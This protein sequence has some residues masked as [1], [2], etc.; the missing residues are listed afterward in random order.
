MTASASHA[1]TAPRTSPASLSEWFPATLTTLRLGP[2]GGIPN[3]SL[4]PCTTSVGT[5]TASSSPSR[6]F[7]GSSPFPGGCT[8]KEAEQRDR[9]EVRGGAARHSRTGRASAHDERKALEA[10]A[11]KL[12]DDR[13]P[14]GIQLPRRGGR[15]SPGDHVGL[16]D[17]GDGDLGVTRRLGGRDEIGGA[18]SARGAVP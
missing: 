5:A 18:H 9:T 2:S 8:G 1:D 14:R 7:D 4:S 13:R 15:L 12:L 17:E 10:V 16:L 11:A 6:L 3:G